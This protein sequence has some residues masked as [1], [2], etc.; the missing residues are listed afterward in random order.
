MAREEQKE[1]GELERRIRGGATAILLDIPANHRLEFFER[2]G[3]GRLGG[4]PMVGEVEG[5]RARNGARIHTRTVHDRFVELLQLVPKVG[6][7]PLWPI[8]Q[9]KNLVL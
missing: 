8:C 1:A 7:A 9:M 3:I 2:C 5:S 4:A 6:V